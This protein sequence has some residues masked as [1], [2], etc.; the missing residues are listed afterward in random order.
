MTNSD[1]LSIIVAI[2]AAIASGL[3]AL[4]AFRSAG[5]AEGARK[6]LEENQV[7]SGRRD[8]SQLVAACSYEHNRILFL[9]HT[10]KIIDQALAFH[11]GALG[12]SRQKLLQDGVST[13]LAM[14]GELFQSASPLRDNPA[15]IGRLVQEDI[16]RLQV[17]LTVRVAALRGIAEELDRDS[18]SRE[19]QLLQHRERAINGGQ[20]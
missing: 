17:E 9:A 19:A 6:A 13:R 20:K 14:A 1:S 8:V 15:A 5:S 2:C 7:R 4:A 10:L 3:A 18:A 16:D 11:A 12:G